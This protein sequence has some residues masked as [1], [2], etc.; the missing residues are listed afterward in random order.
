MQNKGLVSSRTRNER[1]VMKTAK[2][3]YVTP[4]FYFQGLGGNGYSKS[5][6]ELKNKVQSLIEE[7]TTI[8]KNNK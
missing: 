5:M 3:T 8:I 7:H 1:R 4:Q 6:T 2:N